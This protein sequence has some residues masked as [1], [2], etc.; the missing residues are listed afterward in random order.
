MFEPW[1]YIGVQR[2]T[3]PRGSE[4]EIKINLMVKVWCRNVECRSYGV[5][6]LYKEYLY[7]YDTEH[8][9]GIII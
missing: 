7:M 5:Y 9:D 4:P 3:T 8:M 1:T 2:V 6:K